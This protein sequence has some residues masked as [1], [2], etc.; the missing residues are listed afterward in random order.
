MQTQNVKYTNKD[1]ILTIAQGT[2]RIE[3]G[4]FIEVDFKEMHVPASVKV[5]EY[6]LDLSEQLEADL[7]LYGSDTE[8]R[9][10]DH[11]SR[12]VK[13]CIYVIPE[14]EPHYVEQLDE[15]HP[16]NWREAISIEPMPTDK[17]HHYGA[18]EVRGANEKPSPQQQAKLMALEGKYQRMLAEWEV[19]CAGPFAAALVELRADEE[20]FKSSFKLVKRR[21]WQFPFCNKPQPEKAHNRI[22][23]AL[24]Y[25]QYLVDEFNA[26]AT[27]IKANTAKVD[28]LMRGAK[29]R[30]ISSAIKRMQQLNAECQRLIAEGTDNLHSLRNHIPDLKADLPKLVAKPTFSLKR[31]LITIGILL[32]VCLP[33]T[34][35]FI[36]SPVVD[37]VCLKLWGIVL[38][39]FCI[40]FVW[41][42]DDFVLVVTEHS[43][44]SVEYREERMSKLKKSIFYKVFYH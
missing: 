18:V 13:A 41:W 11:L 12:I 2:E 19:R 15:T 35:R 16:A 22:S 36:D 32:S 42:N 14:H 29:V 8:I 27:K 17:L 28:A 1:G 4:T 33:L 6:P 3:E 25:G 26:T 21:F 40:Y 10:A 20:I 9:F 5:L 44:G 43:D 24:R 39:A 31:T 38:I 34:A 23:F 30:S 37:D 7:Y